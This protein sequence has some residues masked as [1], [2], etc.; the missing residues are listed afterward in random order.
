[1]GCNYCKPLDLIEKEEVEIYA[2][3]IKREYLIS[4]ILYYEWACEKWKEAAMRTACIRAL[5]EAKLVTYKNRV[6]FLNKIPQRVLL[7]ES[8]Q[9]S[10]RNE[11][12]ET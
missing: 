4:S 7:D 6:K 10:L 5:E 2:R 3:G 11:W 9:D 8:F 12:V 1:M